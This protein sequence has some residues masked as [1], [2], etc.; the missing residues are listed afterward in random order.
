MKPSP[1]SILKLSDLKPFGIGGR[2]FCFVHPLEPAKCIK[3]LRQDDRRTVRTRGSW[4]IPARF[5]RAYDNN[6]HE[7]AVLSQLARRIGPAVAQHLPRS[8]GYVDTDMGPGLV[9]DL[10]RDADGK[11]SR[12]LRELISIGQ[13]VEQ[14]RPAFE[15]LTRFMVEHRV[16]TRAVL[17]HNI[18]VQDRGDGSWRM[19]IIDGL[20]DS[21]WV[22]LA[23][24]IAPIGRAKIRKRMADAW[25]RF[26]KLARSPVTPELIQ[27]STWGQGFLDHR[28]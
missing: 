27:K 19:V 8:Y 20:G 23:R 6:A 11:I 1:D 3:V 2:R 5:R 25:P 24:W 4:L 21:A 10:V 12:S 13:P 22:P 16:L 18:A 9:L 14:F 28:G 15:E 26:E 7:H 17:D